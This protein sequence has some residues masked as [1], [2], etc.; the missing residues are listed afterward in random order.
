MTADRKIEIIGAESLGVRSLCCRVTLPHRRIIIDPGVALGYMRN[1]LKPHPYQI[2]IGRSIREKILRALNSATDVVFS[3]F[4]GDHVPLVKANPYQLAMGELPEA[5]G[6][7][8]CWSKSG[9]GLS[10]GMRKRFDDLA[11][12][13]GPRMRVAEGISAGE[14]TFSR[15]VPH[16]AAGGNMGSVMMTRVTMGRRVFVHASDIQLLDGPTVDRVIDWHPDILLAS[17]PPLYLDRLSDTARDS[18]WEN[19]RRL[20]RHIEVVILDHHL[21]RSE[22]GTVWLN[23]LSASAGRKVYCAADYM[24]LPRQLL[25]AKRAELYDQMPVSMGWHDA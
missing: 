9:D 21:M 24:G 3:H 16:G 13:L 17:G 12:R 22:E 15:S 18:A 6:Q 5:F 19:A 7:L 1:G 4:H 25:E 10:A 14:L 8:R 23:A 11:D 20:V 2:A